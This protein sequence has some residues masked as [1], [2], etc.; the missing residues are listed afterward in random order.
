MRTPGM[1]FQESPDG[2]ISNL[3]NFQ[4][5]NKTNKPISVKI[6][7]NTAGAS[8]KMIGTLNTLPPAEVSKGS[9]F[10]YL[11]KDKLHD[12]KTEVNITIL[13]GQKVVASTRTNFMGPVTFK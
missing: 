8:V 6:I 7:T 9:L 4:L 10:I 3:Y 11:P 13:Q 12:H 5:A 1:L 2:N